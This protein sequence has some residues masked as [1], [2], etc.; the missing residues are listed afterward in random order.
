MSIRSFSCQLVLLL[1]LCSL[2]Y[3]QIDPRLLTAIRQNDPRAL[4]AALKAGANPNIT[5]SLGAT[6]LMWACFKADTTV[7]NLLIKAGAKTECKGVIRTDT[8]TYYGNLTGLAAG[9]NK[10][11]LLRYL[12]ETLKLP[13]NEP[14]YNPETKQNDGWTPAEW[15]A[16][17]GHLEL[18]TY[19]AGHGADLTVGKGNPIALATSRERTPTVAFLLEKGLILSKDNPYYSQ[20]SGRYIQ[21]LVKL[22]KTYQAEGKY[23]QAV[24][25]WEQIQDIYGAEVSRQDTTYV[26][27]INNI[28]SLYKEMGQY[29][30]ALPLYLEILKHP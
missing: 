13:V 9:L 3:A 30:K 14:E 5:D 24:R 23:A 21:Q 8:S 2:A 6:P 4:E 7:V 26:T 27:I 16:N 29:T 22:D 11:P 17:Y 10:L 25:C 19:L 15:A 20:I 18:L 12:L 28:G 1:S